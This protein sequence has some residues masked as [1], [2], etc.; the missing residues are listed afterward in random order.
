MAVN[1]DLIKARLRV[2][3][4]KA[5]L[6]KERLDELS[7][8]LSKLPADDADEAA[9]DAVLDNADAMMPFEE[10]ARNDDTIRTL[11]AKAQEPPKPADP[12]K[13]NEP[14][15]PDDNT[16][17][18][19]KAMLA[20]IEKQAKDLEDL[21]LGKVTE[22]KLQQ[23]KNLFDKSEVFKGIA[24]ENAKEFFLK[25]IDVNSDTPFE[26]QIKQ[27]EEVHSKLVQG[28]A[29]AEDYAGDPAG[30]VPNG[31]PTDAEIDSIIANAAR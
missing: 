4:P 19:A 10:I 13:P 17:E 24:D 9:I 5:N 16:P 25:Q 26:D 12:P 29:D 11:K 18:W 28:R 20:T 15:K 22:T 7:A 27:L 3:F 21:K 14:P 2:K 6:S 1:P 31:G 8:R 23:A 30:G